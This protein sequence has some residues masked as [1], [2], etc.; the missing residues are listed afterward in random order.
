MSWP[1]KDDTFD[2]FLRYAFSITALKLNPRVQYRVLYFFNSAIKDSVI[3]PTKTHIFLQ[4]LAENGKL[5]SVI[6]QNI[7]D[8]ELDVGLSTILDDFVIQAH[9]S[10]K[11]H[12]ICINFDC[13]VNTI[14]KAH[15]DGHQLHN[16]YQKC[17]HDGHPSI[18]E[19]T[20]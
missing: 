3:K 1:N 18:F 16:K 7:D 2:S 11:K 8:L 9:G 13:P 6:T 15:A 4:Y 19:N 5:T 17:A 12:P 14:D 10:L 20:S